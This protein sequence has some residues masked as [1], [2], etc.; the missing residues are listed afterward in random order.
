[1]QPIEL[2][3]QGNFYDSQIYRGKLYLWH[4][5]GRLSVYDW[6]QLIYNIDVPDYLAFVKELCLLDGSYLYK[7]YLYDRLLNDKEIKNIVED[8][9]RRL[10]GLQFI[11]N[12]E[13]LA[14]YVIKE[15]DVPLGEMPLDVHI[16]NKKLYYTLDNGQYVSQLK[17]NN[18]PLSALK[19]PNKIFDGRVVHMAVNNGRMAMSM[20]SD[21]LYERNV[22]DYFEEREP[23]QISNRHSSFAYYNYSNIFNT[24]LQ[25]ESFLI[26][27]SPLMDDEEIDYGRQFA[28]QRI[29]RVSAILYD[30]NGI[31]Q[32]GNH[33]NIGW[34]FNNRIYYS[35]GKQ[36]T[37]VQYS[38]YN[39]DSIFKILK[40]NVSIEQAP[41]EKI[42]N[43]AVAYFGNI[44]EY[45]SKLV[46]L[47]SDGNV[48]EISEPITRWRVFP[49]SIN[50]ENHLHVILDDCL[51]VYGFIHDYT[52]N[53]RNK[54]MGAYFVNRQYR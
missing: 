29:N 7:T 20:L 19:R 42:V 14:K 18:E 35:N 21:G 24:S 22:A 11:I 9:I 50:Y 53:E 54:T 44:V 26:Y 33:G 16:Y 10:S 48:L 46:V 27:N 6:N 3:I 47:Q 23:R 52:S 4:F 49:R 40:D 1:M 39:R 30:E 25:G 12:E 37:A 31:T 32:K 34:G 36:I 17:G 8:K 51:C 5:D 2:K 43:A 28:R 45:M 15:Y 41:D 13:E 38:G